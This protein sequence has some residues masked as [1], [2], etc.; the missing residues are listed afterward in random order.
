MDNF[1]IIIPN[2]KE[3]TYKVVTFIIGLMNI[4]AFMYFRV[5]SNIILEQNVSLVASAL[6]LSFFVF[7]LLST[8]VN[9][10]K[11]IWLG[12]LACC[13]FWGVL[14]FYILA[15]LMVIFTFLGFIS[16]RTIKIV[17]DHNGVK[18]PS[19]P[20]KVFPWNAISQVLLKDGVLTIDLENNKL[21]QITLAKEVADH[22]DPS[23]FNRSCIDLK[24]NSS[25]V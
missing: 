19:F 14:E 7:Y 16:S 6:M 24:N 11:I 15:L 9:G 18:Y 22:I 13:I 4:F 1:N 2:N 5:K 12:F 17:I 21:I 3:A 20:P 23:V 10:R 25:E 8:S